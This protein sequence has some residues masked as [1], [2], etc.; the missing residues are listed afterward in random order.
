MEMFNVYLVCLIVGALLSVISL[1]SSSIGGLDLDFDL[2]LDMDFDMGGVALPLKP[3]TI[4]VFV[5]VFGGAGM[6]SL[7]YCPPLLSLIPAVLAGLLVAAAVHYLLYVKLKR[8][9]TE[10]P[11][12]NDAI[13]KRA[14][15]VERIPPGGYGKIS[16]VMDGNTLSGAAKEK[17]SG[18]GIEKGRHVYILDRRDNVYYVCEHL[19]LYLKQSEL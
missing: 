4:L 16:Y 5:T 8:Y 9:E 14:Q 3:T 19:E 12:E 1:L 7:N 6:I 18:E 10:A 11:R 17:T 15:V 2:D 13:M